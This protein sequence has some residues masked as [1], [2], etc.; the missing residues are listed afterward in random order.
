MNGSRDEEPDPGWS[1]GAVLY[2]LA[3]VVFWLVLVWIVSRS[4]A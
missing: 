4:S 1:D 3:E 2:V